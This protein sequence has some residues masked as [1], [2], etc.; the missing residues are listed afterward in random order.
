MRLF[1][2]I[3]ATVIA[4]LAL[5]ACAFLFYQFNLA[6]FLPQWLRIVMQV[7]CGI[8]MFATLRVWGIAVI[9]RKSDTY[10]KSKY[11]SK[12]DDDKDN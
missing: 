2:T 9:M 8:G 7:L 6:A 10:G 4:L 12:A 11:N 5:A 1:K 3:F